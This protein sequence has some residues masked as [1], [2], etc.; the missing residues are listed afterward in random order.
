MDKINVGIGDY[1]VA[2]EEGVLATVL[3]S[4]VGVILYDKLR[5]IGG[6]A[7]VYLPDSQQGKKFEPTCGDTSFDRSL[8]YADLLVP[9]VVEEMA[10]LG[11]STRQLVAYLVGGAMLFEFPKDSSLNVGLRNL[12]MVKRTLRE[13]GLWAL[14]V[15]VGGRRGR[16]VNFDVATGDL[17]VQDLP[18]Q[19]SSSA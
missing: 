9:R 2:A 3:G 5:R 19:A 1:A 11:A 8:K 6:L 17:Q 4:C 18:G 16:K 13:F 7:H 12:E 10:A 14:E 15:K